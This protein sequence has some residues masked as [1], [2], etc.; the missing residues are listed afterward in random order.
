MSD[1]RIE[2]RDLIIG[3][4]LILFGSSIASA[5]F[6]ISALADLRIAVGFLFGALIMAG[7][8]FIER[9]F[10]GRDASG[11]S[12]QRSSVSSYASGHPGQSER[13]NSR[14]MT[15]TTSRQD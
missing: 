7:Y 8:S 14:S 15:R 9:S 5:P 2:I 10:M 11:T 3:L 13:A 4:F 12:G 6:L 1:S